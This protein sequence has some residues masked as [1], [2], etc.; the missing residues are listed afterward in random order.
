M[1]NSSADVDGTKSTRSGRVEQ[2]GVCL[3]RGS[4][5]LRGWK[6]ISL[7]ENYSEFD[8]FEPA[9][10][11]GII[12]WSHLSSTA[13]EPENSEVPREHLVPRAIS[14]RLHD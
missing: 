11:Q 1:G 5:V 13:V 10:S 14:L 7:T 9:V 6:Q 12:F 3:R 2:A 4:P 8:G